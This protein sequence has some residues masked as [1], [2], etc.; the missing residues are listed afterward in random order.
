MT[1]YIT[2]KAYSANLY[3][4]QLQQGESYEE[5][6]KK[7]L[8]YGKIKN[9][10]KFIINWVPLI[11]AG[12][13]G[14]AANFIYNLKINAII[15]NKYIKKFFLDALGAALVAPFCALL[16]SDKFRLFAAFATGLCWAVIIQ[17]IR[18]AITKKIEECLNK[19]R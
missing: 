10:E 12:S 17:I 5:T 7:L 3:Q 15:N 13:A 6:F 16:F 8:F 1:R 11:L 2:I 4:K 9:M 18:K 19:F 14:G